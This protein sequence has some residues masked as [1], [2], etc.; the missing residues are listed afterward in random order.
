[1]GI[2]A[3]SPHII[4][5]ATSAMR[6]RTSTSTQKILF[7]IQVIVPSCVLWCWVQ[8]FAELMMVT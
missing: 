1:M 4:G 2:V 6:L 5:R 3:T 7:S 8:L